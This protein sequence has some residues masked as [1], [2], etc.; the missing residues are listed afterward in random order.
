MYYVYILKSLRDGRYYY[1]CTSNLETRLKSHNSG[2]VRSI[3]SRRPLIL[4]YYEEFESKPEALKRERFFKSVTGNIWLKEQ[5][6][7]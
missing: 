1:G 3:K 5:G 7:I 2:K 6:I 4:H